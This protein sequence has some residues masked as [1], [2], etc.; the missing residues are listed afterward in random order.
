MPLSRYLWFTLQPM[1]TGCNHFMPFRTRAAG[2]RYD[3]T[4]HPHCY[5]CLLLSLD[6]IQ[7][8]QLG[9]QQFFA[10]ETNPGPSTAPNTAPISDLSATPNR[11]P[12]AG[13]SASDHTSMALAENQHHL[14]LSDLTQDEQHTLLLDWLEIGDNLGSVT[15]KQKTKV[16]S[17]ESSKA[18]WT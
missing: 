13:P 1:L 4:F 6:Q 9:L 2:H 12:N 7:L 16:G 10:S 3:H 17:T 5:F 8:L 11:T 18:A 15:G 14:L